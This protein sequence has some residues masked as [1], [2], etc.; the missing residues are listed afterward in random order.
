[1]FSRPRSRG[2]R[3]AIPISTSRSRPFSLSTIATFKVPGFYDGDGSLSR[4]VHAGR[5][6]RMDLSRRSSNVAE[7]DG[8]DGR[9]LCARAARR[10]CMDRCSVRNKFH[11]AHADGTPYFPFGTTC[12]AWTHQPLEMQAQT[13]ATL[14]GARF[15]KLRMGGLPEGLHLQR[16]RA[17]LS[18]SS[19]RTRPA[20]RTSIARTR[21]CSGISRRRSAALRELGVEADIIIFH[22]Y[23]RWGYCDMGAERDFRYVRYLV[24]RLAAFCQR[25]VVARQRIRFPARLQADRAMGSL[26]SHHRGKRSLSARQIDP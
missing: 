19:S 16:E 15:N 5:A 22:P 26:F 25:L 13:L 21:G 6:G 8:Q 10:A 2:R 24:A 17:A 11:F 14:K 18:R 1:M 23:D 12:Y 4:A 3:R 9:F 20:R 7:L